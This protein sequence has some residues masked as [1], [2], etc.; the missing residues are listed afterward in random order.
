MAIKKAEKK[1]EKKGRRSFED[2]RKG[3]I[4]VED[5]SIEEMTLKPE[6]GRKLLKLGF[7]EKH[8]LKKNAEHTFIVRM[9]FA[10]GTAK[11][12]AVHSKS[13]TFTYKGKTYYLFYEE[14]Y[15]DLS[16]NQFLFIFHENFSVPINRE[17]VEKA[18]KEGDEAYFVVKPGVLKDYG[19]MESLRAVVGKGDQDKLMLIVLIVSAASALLSLFTLILMFRA[20]K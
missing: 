16:L 18:E 2:I 6:K 14:C 12:F 10:N 9:L 11:E 17:I 1:A 20:G 5:G 7:W 8:H 4:E 15:F 3:A 13:Q 19:K